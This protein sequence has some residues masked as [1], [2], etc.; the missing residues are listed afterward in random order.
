MLIAEAASGDT[1]E[2][3]N[4]PYYEQIPMDGSK[5][6]KAGALSRRICL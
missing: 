4:D 3:D 1:D 5:P 6:M 2:D